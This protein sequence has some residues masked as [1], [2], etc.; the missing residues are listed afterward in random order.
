VLGA[1]WKELTE[2]QKAPYNKKA[3][4]DKKRYEAEKESYAVYYRPAPSCLHSLLTFPRVVLVPL[5][6]RMTS[7]R[8]VPFNVT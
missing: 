8:L 2:S 3:E 5:T 7:R 6:T 1:K 4:V